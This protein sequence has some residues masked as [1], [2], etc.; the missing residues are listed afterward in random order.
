MTRI[1]V[2]TG[3]TRGIGAAIAT[4]LKER[5]FKVAANYA[6]NEERAREFAESTGIPVYKF[7]VSDFA[8]CQEGIAR[9]TADLGLSLIHI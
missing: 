8:Q 7:D 5:G 6:G 3:G 2:V 4:G 9:I 1:A